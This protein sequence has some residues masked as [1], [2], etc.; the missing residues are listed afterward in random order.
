MIDFHSHLDLYP[1]GLKLAQEVNRRNEFTL[2]VTT[3]PRAYRAT[4]RVFLGLKNIKVGIGLH[5]EV[6]V[7][8]QRELDDLIGGISLARFVGEIGM[9]GSTR[10]RDSLSV[11]E[12]IFQAA[13]AECG[14]WQGRVM[15]IHSRGAE[16][17]VVELLATT[18]HAGVP[19]L[20]WFSGGFA[21]LETAVRI[22]CWFSVGPAMLK[23]AKGRALV[24]RMP[25]TRV[26]PETDGP[27]TSVGGMQLQPWD[28]WSVRAPLAAIWGMPLNEVGEQLRQNLGQL[29]QLSVEG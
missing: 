19:V 11:Q 5:P 21:E 4:S 9:D 2:V 12:P 27:F 18:K 22:G 25:S 15:S 24:A 14:R 7:A 17:R 23:G 26:L 20:H 28:A 1:D 13:L 3:S 10:F 8:K 16:R 29:L 6:A